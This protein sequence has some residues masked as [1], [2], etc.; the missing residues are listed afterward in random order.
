MIYG[1]C[2]INVIHSIMCQVCFALRMIKHTYNS[3]LC[4]SAPVFDKLLLNDSSK[5]VLFTKKIIV[6]DF[7]KP[8]I[9]ARLDLFNVRMS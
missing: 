1:D 9:T 3:C 6:T 2:K 5:N 4:F 7:N 8:D